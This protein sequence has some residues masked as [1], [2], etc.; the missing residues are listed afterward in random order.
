MAL[1][2]S[3]ICSDKQNDILTKRAHDE[4]CRNGAQVRN[5]FGTYKAF[6][7]GMYWASANEQNSRY[8]KA[9][10]QAARNEVWEAF[11]LGQR[12]ATMM[13]TAPAALAYRPD[14]ASL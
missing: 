13:S 6:G 4:M 2:N 8:L 5:Q 14:P 3:G 7:D 12:Q 1:H 9:A 10:L 11:S